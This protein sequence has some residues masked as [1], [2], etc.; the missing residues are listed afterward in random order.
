[1]ATR[2]AFHSPTLAETLAS[3]DAPRAPR[4][5]VA[6]STPEQMAAAR[7]AARAAAYATVRHDGLMAGE[8]LV[9]GEVYVFNADSRDADI[10]ASLASRALQMA[11]E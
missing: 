3:L 7:A 8:R 4:Q 1:M 2:P 6:K 11:A 10:E 5:P 9:N